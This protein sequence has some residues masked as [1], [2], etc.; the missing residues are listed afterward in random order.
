MG[1]VRP[2][3][4]LFINIHDACMTCKKQ[5]YPFMIFHLIFQV[6]SKF[7]PFEHFG[8]PFLKIIEIF[9][10]RQPLFGEF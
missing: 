2:Q 9:K 7:F 8:A 5:Q 10:K 1:G 4:D 3:S 6:F